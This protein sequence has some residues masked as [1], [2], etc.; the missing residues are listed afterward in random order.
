[1][2]DWMSMPLAVPISSEAYLRRHAPGERAAVSG[3]P[4]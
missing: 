3:D 4:A 1:M 2:K